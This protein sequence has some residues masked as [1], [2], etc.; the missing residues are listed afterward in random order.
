MMSLGLVVPKT[1]S[2]F[3]RKPNALSSFPPEPLGSKQGSAALSRRAFF[4]DEKTLL[5]QRILQHRRQLNLS[6]MSEAEDAISEQLYFL[7]AFRSAKKSSTFC[8][9]ID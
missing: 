3:I 9:I 4:M 7:D 5:R 6:Y 8:I 1:L 2:Y